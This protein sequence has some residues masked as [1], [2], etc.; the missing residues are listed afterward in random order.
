MGA[1]LVV[2]L[3]GAC[4][5]VSPT[6][7]D[8]TPSTGGTAGPTPTRSETSTGPTGSPT[9]SAAER[10]VGTRLLAA[11]SEFGPML[12]DAR[13]QAIYLF[14]L[15]T[16]TEP[17]CYR[18]C[19]E[20]WPPV[21]TEGRPR[22]G[23]GLDQRLLGTTRRNDGTTQVTYGGH[24]LYFYA[25]EAPREVRCHDVLLNGGTWYVVRPDGTPAP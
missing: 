15:E 4:A 5:E 8:P 12:F 9:P 17:R 11:S 21:L 1:L 20:A 2:V 25:H 22:A 23:R 6:A 16:T 3:L 10:P 24:P 18:E 13:G 14:D 19:A 7:T